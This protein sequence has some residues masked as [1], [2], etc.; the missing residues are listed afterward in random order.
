M[1]SPYLRIDFRDLARSVGLDVQIFIE[2]VQ[3]L[4][5]DENPKTRSS[6]FGWQAYYPLTDVYD[7]L[8]SLETTYE[9]RVSIINIGKSYEGRDILGVKISSKR[10]GS[11]AIFLES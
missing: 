8:R 9:D 10:E 4:I 6:T 1:V 11:K 7:W 5:Q 2:D 3:K